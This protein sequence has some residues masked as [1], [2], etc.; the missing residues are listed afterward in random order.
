M[1]GRV[2]DLHFRIAGQRSRGACQCPSKEIDA[3]GHPRLPSELSKSSKGLAQK[4][5][6][7]GK[8]KYYRKF[9]IC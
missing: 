9:I 2:D 3:L 6:M 1:I 8:G 7:S 5:T 4:G